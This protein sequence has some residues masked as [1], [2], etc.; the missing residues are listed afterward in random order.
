MNKQEN[1]YKKYNINNL[2]I[3]GKEISDKETAYIDVMISSL[4]I[5]NSLNNLRNSLKNFKPFKEKK[6]VLNIF[7]PEDIMKNETIKFINLLIKQK[8]MENSNINYFFKDY[9]VEVEDNAIKLSFA[10]KTEK[11]ILETT[12]QEI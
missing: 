9:F 5:E 11:N 4:E 2:E 6:I 7:A 1:F 10:S 8:K 3:I 12:N